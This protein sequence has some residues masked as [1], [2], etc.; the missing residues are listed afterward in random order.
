MGAPVG[1][2]KTDLEIPYPAAADGAREWAGPKPEIRFDHSWKDAARRIRLSSPPAIGPVRAGATRIGGTRLL[3][4]ARIRG[5]S[6]IP[7][8]FARCRALYPAAILVT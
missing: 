2:P 7:G 1:I 4:R 8:G 5:G 3:K 6:Q